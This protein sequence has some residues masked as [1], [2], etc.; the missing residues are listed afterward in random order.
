MWY[1]I[2]LNHAHGTHVL[3]SS[4]LSTNG[5][6]PNSNPKLLIDANMDHPWSIRIPQHYPNLYTYKLEASSGYEWVRTASIT[7]DLRLHA[8]PPTP[9][10]HIYIYGRHSTHFGSSIR[11]QNTS[12]THLI[13][14]NITP[15]I[16]DASLTCPFSCRPYHV[17][18]MRHST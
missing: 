1:P 11:L 16:F 6:N 2:W 15:V 5:S 18:A 17:S 8:W 14:F 12:S 4:S 10:A 7:W 13:W 3:G 9:C